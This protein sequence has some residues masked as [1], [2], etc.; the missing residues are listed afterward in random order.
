MN[1]FSQFASRHSEPVEAEIRRRIG[2]SGKITFAE[3]MRLAL[4]HPQGGYYTT[5]SA[6]GVSGDYFTSPAAHPA[7]GALLAIQFE[8]MW[9]ALGSPERFFVV[10][11]GAGDGLLARDVISYVPI[12]S[13]K[14]GEAL[15]YVAIDR[16]APQSDIHVTQVQRIISDGLPLRDVAGCIVSNEL[17]DAFPVNR[18]VVKR[19]EVQEAFVTLND[20]GNFAEIFDE[21]SSS[22]IRYRVESLGFELSEGFQGEVNRH[23][24]PWMKSVSDALGRGFVITIDYGYEAYELYS[25][26]HRVG[27]FQTYYRHTEGSSPYQRIGRQD[28]T[29][30]V[31]FSLV[32]SEGREHALR[33]LGLLT[34]S[35]FLKG[36]GFDSM[37]RNMRVRDINSRERAVNTTA[38][39]EL[40]SKEGFG[41][42]KVLIQ[43]RGTSVH[44]LSTL[45]P[46]PTPT[47]D[48]EA[49]LIST[50]HVRPLDGRY[51]GP[52]VEVQELWPFEDNR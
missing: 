11:L 48:I 52:T 42:F 29:A 15:R 28:M 26:I 35:Q 21:P 33:S 3:F 34:Q 4:Y 7:F 5:P 13:K 17:L 18:F 23:I 12:V 27:T 2:E 44:D 40:V 36:L 6:F 8:R 41:E 51:A 37:L 32:E 16:Y 49:P 46:D 31:D 43:E 45:L 19:G 22:S 30:H 39:I 9:L 47:F 25:E 50:N 14:F 1:P 20:E 10:E 38:M 24:R